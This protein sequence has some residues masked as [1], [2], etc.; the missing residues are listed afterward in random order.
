M[1]KVKETL[2]KILGGVK[3]KWTDIG[4][5]GHII[6]FSVAGVVIISAIIAIVLATRTEYAVLYPDASPEEATEI[7]AIVKLLLVL[8]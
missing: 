7:L 2:T 6:F 4:R 1:D 3:T 5:K 8:F